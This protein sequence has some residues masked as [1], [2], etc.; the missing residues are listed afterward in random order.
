MSGRAR[1]RIDGTGRIIPG[2]GRSAGASRSGDVFRPETPDAQPRAAQ[3]SSLAASTGIDALLALQSVDDATTGRRKTVRR[4]NL[5][6]D[7]LEEIRADLLSGHVSEGRLNRAIV[8]LT[9]AKVATDPGLDAL[10]AD[11]ELRVRVE[12]AKLGRYPPL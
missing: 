6:L 1:M 2:T 4:A 12:L 8:L 5:L 3:T 7:A 9:Q 11:I 10:V